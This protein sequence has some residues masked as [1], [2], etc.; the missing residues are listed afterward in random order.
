MHRP[1]PAF[2]LP[3]LWLG[4]G[5]PASDP[6]PG[7]ELM[8][9]AIIEVTQEPGAR[10]RV[11]AQIENFRS[12]A[13]VRATVYFA[14][15]VDELPPIEVASIAAANFSVDS[16]PLAAHSDHSVTVNIL[17]RDGLRSQEQRSFRTGSFEISEVTPAVSDATTL[18]VT[19]YGLSSGQGLRLGIRATPDATEERVDLLATTCTATVCTG[20]V[21]I[22][23]SLPPGEPRR[24]TGAV[25]PSQVYLW[26]NGADQQPFDSAVGT[27]QLAYRS[28]PPVPASGAAGSEFELLLF[29]PARAP[30][31][32]GLTVRFDDTALSPIAATEHADLAGGGLIYFTRAR[33]RVPAAAVA[34][35]H[36]IGVASD[37][38]E[39]F[40]ASSATF[41]V[42]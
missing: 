11:A 21:P 14:G 10:Y 16:E 32:L 25:P 40:L 22:L 39:S 29:H 13:G 37:L 24:I 18:T 6:D 8:R 4:A 7:D 33:F 41:T 23:L 36:T 35:S 26:T 15:G 2:L 20:T 34:G 5:C 1:P 38:G 3:V 27:T 12:D 9:V 28:G 17:D 19:G 42:Q 31:L 30:L